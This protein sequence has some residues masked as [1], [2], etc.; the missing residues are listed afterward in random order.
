VSA[1]PSQSVL[2]ALAPRGTASSNL[3]AAGALALAKSSGKQ[4]P[5]QL[6]WWSDAQA[7]KDKVTL[8]KQLG[9]R[10]VAIF[11]L[12]GGEDPAMWSVLK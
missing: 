11:K 2:S 7:I 3:A 12:D 5:V 1:L 10:G 9:L 8:A 6:L 4:S